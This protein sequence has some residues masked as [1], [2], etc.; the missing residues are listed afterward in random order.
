MCGQNK[1]GFQKSLGHGCSS[2]LLLFP[3]K[4]EQ[5]LGVRIKGCTEDSSAYVNNEEIRS[6]RGYRSQ[7]RLEFG[8]KNN[9][10]FTILFMA[11]NSWPIGNPLSGFFTGRIGVL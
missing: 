8:S 9:M 1:W 11:H 4:G 3:C 10:G 7:D 2:I 5:V 6:V